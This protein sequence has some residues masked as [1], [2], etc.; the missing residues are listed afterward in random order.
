MRGVADRGQQAMNDGIMRP[1]HEG[2][3]DMKIGSDAFGEV[4]EYV[5][6]ITTSL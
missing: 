5:R 6:L 1:S 3:R 2:F 4:E